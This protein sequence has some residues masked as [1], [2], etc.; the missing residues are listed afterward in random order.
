[1]HELAMSC[2]ACGNQTT[3]DVLVDVRLCAHCSADP[4]MARILVEERIIVCEEHMHA[5]DAALDTTLEGA[6]FADL[7]RYTAL[8]DARLSAR[9]A[10]AATSDGWARHQRREAKTIA[11]GDGLSVILRAE[12]QHRHRARRI[13]R[14]YAYHHD[15][16]LDLDLLTNGAAWTI[17]TAL[18][19]RR[20]RLYTQRTP[21]TPQWSGVEVVDPH[22]D[23]SPARTDLWQRSV[24]P[25]ISPLNRIVPQKWHQQSSAILAIIDAE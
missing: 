2:R 10:V 24:L 15:T 7:V 8:L 13:Q 4:L 17:P 18:V 5:T 21:G 9:Q 11:L 1:M 23:Q 12:H 3:S 19:E 25:G 16:H 20:R 6:C 22:P 14:E